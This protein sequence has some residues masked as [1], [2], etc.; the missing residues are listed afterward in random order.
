MA[1]TRLSA[2]LRHVLSAEDEAELG[3]RTEPRLDL[4]REMLREVHPVRHGYDEKLG[5]P[6]RRPIEEF[7]HHVLFRR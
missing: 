4:G 7:V 1:G 3:S 5:I 6:H 2:N